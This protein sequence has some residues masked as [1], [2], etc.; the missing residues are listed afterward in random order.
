MTNGKTL[1]KKMK[2]LCKPSDNYMKYRRKLTL[3]TQDTKASFK[4]FYSELKDLY[5]F[6]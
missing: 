6:M 1:M 5:K 2:E 3:L 4:A